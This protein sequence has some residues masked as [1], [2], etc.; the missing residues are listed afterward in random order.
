VLTT[1]VVRDVERATPRAKLVRIDLGGAAFEYAPGQAIL[2]APHGHTE[3]RPYSIASAPEDAKR[4]GVID[5]LVGIET[6]GNGA[7]SA[8]AQGAERGSGVPASERAGVWGRAPGKD[9]WIFDP[10]PGDR[11]DV[12]GPLG[13]FT[14]PD[15]PAERRFVFIAGGTGIAPL[16]AMLRH[17]L[18]IPHD[19]IGVF[20]SA[21]TPDEFAFEREF[22]ALAD[23]GAIDLRLT[24]TRDA[25]DGW[26][27][28]RGRATTDSL[29]PVVER[30][31]TLCF[32]CGPASMVDDVPKALT[33]LGIR[34]D[35]IRI[36][37]W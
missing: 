18:G 33:R 5:L 35:L 25:H 11:V 14:F 27:G 37:E 13:S 21:R 6:G 15:N 32:V 4:S 16:R 20:Y 9:D 26:T 8:P 31:G 12:E 23:A 24:V 7:R 28:G 19:R 30:P 29:R 34:P 22:R 1:L 17:A 2:L 36:E 3:R 10:A